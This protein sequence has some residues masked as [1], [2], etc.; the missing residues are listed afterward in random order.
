MISMSITAGS[1]MPK[2][3]PAMLDLIIRLS[4]TMA[5]DG[6]PML[7]SFVPII[8]QILEHFEL[9]QQQI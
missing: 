7:D 1:T 3:K 9:P 8:K 4:Q 6:M 5:E 2:N